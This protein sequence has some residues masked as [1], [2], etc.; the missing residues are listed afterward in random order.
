VDPLSG[1]IELLTVQSAVSSRLE[2]GGTW[3]L[4]FPGVAHV[5]FGAVHRGEAWLRVGPDGDEVHLT[6]G[7]CFAL[8]T[9][10][11]YAVAG[12]P[13]LDP[14]DGLPAFRSAVDGV[15]RVGTGDEVV[16]TGGR[17]VFDDRSARLLLDVLPPLLVVSAGHEHAAPLRAALELF[18]QETASRQLGGSLLT[19]LLSQV[20]FVAALRAAVD[21]RASQVRGWLAALSDERIGE[22]LRLM[23]DDPSRRWTV[24]EL[25]RTAAMSRSTFAGRFRTLVGAPPLDHLLRLRMHAAGRDLRRGDTTVSAVGASWGYTSDAAFSNAFKRVMGTSPSRWRTQETPLPP[26]DTTDA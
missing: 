9:G 19:G 2:A 20:V 15:A 7:D 26:R 6:A 13:G 23:H 22:V 12:A 24:P 4:S 5:K 1:V 25:A 18:A 21:T 17:F 8:T 11:G 14:V 3:A 10:S 16:L